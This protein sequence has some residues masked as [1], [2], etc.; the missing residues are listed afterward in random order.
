MRTIHDPLQHAHVL[1][2]ARPQ[3]LAVFVLAEPVDMIDPGSLAQGALHLDPVPEIIAHVIAAERQHGH[4]IA[5]DLPHRP[6]DG[7]SGLRTHCGA[8]VNTP[9]PIEGLIYER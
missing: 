1:A 6:D 8:R 7:C 9:G 5:A 2:E 3:E 4:W